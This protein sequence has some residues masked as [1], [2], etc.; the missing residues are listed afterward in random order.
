MRTVLTTILLTGLLGVSAPIPQVPAPEFTHRDAG[1]WINSAP[2]T[3]ANLKG[4]VV[5]V[6]FWTFGCSNCLRTLPWLKD[7]H[8]R[9]EGRGLV[10]VSVHS[11]EFDHE[12]DTDQVRAAV[13]RLGIRYPVMVDNDFS[14]WTALRNRYWPAFYLIDREGR[15]VAAE[16]GELHAGQPRSD[17]FERRIAG[18]LPGE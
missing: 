16:F 9:Y 1:A 11:P 13:K 2:L 8:E 6:E 10:V 17:G 4:R 14:Y 15:L 5:L 7:V 3:L 18:L 12:R